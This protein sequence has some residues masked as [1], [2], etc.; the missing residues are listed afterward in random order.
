VIPGVGATR[1]GF[2]GNFLSRLPG[3]DRHI[4]L[5]AGKIYKLDIETGKASPV[6]ETE[7]GRCD[8][9]WRFVADAAGKARIC[10]S[11][12]IPNT[13]IFARLGSSDDWVE[14]YRYSWD[15][16]VARE[17]SFEAFAE[18]PDV[19]YVITRN[20]GERQAAYKFDLKTKSVGALVYQNPKYDVVDYVLEPLT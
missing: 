18:D 13:T 9:S 15:D 12:G 14:I 2:Y 17:V 3:D 8:R 6:S 7:R 10:Y 16:R 20:G 4:L 19:A 5:S 11:G 1:Y